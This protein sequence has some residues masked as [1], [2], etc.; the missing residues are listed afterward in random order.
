LPLAA[1]RKTPWGHLMTPLLPGYHPQQDLSMA[2][3][4]AVPLVACYEQEA[5]ELPRVA[6]SRQWRGPLPAEPLHQQREPQPLQQVVQA[7]QSHQRQQR[8]LAVA[9][10]VAVLVPVA[11]LAQKI[12]PQSLLIPL[13]KR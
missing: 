3:L 4:R 1:L 6:L 5:P 10:A 11:V 8:E 7:A 13:M 9:V 12:A 2:V